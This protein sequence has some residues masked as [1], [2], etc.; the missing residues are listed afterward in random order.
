MKNARLLTFEMLQDRRER[1][2]RDESPAPRSIGVG[3]PRAFVQ[4]ADESRRIRAAVA[5]TVPRRAVQTTPV[6][7]PPAPATTATTATEKFLAVWRGIGPPWMRWALAGAFGLGAVGVATYAFTPRRKR[8]RRSR[9][10]RR[11]RQ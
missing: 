9:S 7:A 4:G 10:S 5:A 2:A 11:R 8:R 1:H 3:A 6:A